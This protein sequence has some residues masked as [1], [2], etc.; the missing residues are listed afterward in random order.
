[1][2]PYLVYLL[3]FARPYHCASTIQARLSPSSPQEAVPVGKDFTSFSIEYSHLP[4][5]AGPYSFYQLTVSGM[6]SSDLS[7]N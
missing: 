2:N 1:M 4:W 3:A 7:G 5:F 6:P